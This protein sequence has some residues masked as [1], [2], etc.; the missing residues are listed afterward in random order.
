MVGPA[1]T[2]TMLFK[3]HGS[4]KPRQQTSDAVRQ[5]KSHIRAS[6]SEFG[7][8]VQKRDSFQFL[9][10]FL[11]NVFSLEKSMKQLWW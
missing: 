2:R 3:P 7:L 1:T 8:E 11:L 10:L 6:D 4:V 5:E 9:F